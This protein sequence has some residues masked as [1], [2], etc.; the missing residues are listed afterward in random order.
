[1]PVIG[2]EK[3]YVAVLTKDDSTGL[4]FNN[5]KYYSG[6]Q[7]LSIKPKQN[8]EKLYAENM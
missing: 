7:T 4:T 5:P 2:I 3:L 6:I 1:M 8:T